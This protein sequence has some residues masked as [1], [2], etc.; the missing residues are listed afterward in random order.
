MDDRGWWRESRVS[1]VVESERVVDAEI[2]R[3]FVPRVG[4]RP[5]GDDSGWTAGA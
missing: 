1:Q 2:A 4:A 5:A 3:R